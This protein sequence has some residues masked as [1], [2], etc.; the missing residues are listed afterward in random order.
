MTTD[1]VTVYPDTTMDKVEEIFKTHDFHHIP[2]ISKAGKLV[3]IISRSDYH[4]ICDKMTLFKEKI[5]NSINTKFL[6]TLLASEVMSR[7]LAKLR[8]EDTVDLAVTYFKENLFHA[9]PVV[10]KDDNLRG[11]ITTF[12]LLNFAFKQPPAY[13]IAPGT[14]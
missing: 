13:I 8:P 2:V 9:V 14:N 4:L 7:Y 6:R 5:D 10:D 3:G 12:D 1:L 11:M